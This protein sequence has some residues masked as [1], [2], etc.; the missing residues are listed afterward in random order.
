MKTKRLILENSTAKT[1][2]KLK[3]QKLKEI[4]ETK[5]RLLK[6]DPELGIHISKNK[7]PK[8]YVQSY[9]L[10]NLWKINLPKNARGCQPILHK[11]FYAIV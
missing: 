5:L 10:T 8:E 6:N 4:I 1:I 7:I 11:E 3:D 2:S 9:E